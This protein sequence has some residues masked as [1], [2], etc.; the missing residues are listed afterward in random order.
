MSF[1]RYLGWCLIPWL[2]WCA[3]VWTNA[4]LIGGDL[5]IPRVATL[6]ILLVPFFQKVSTIAIFMKLGSLVQAIRLRRL[7][8]SFEVHRYGFV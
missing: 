5:H 4:G 6:C 2:V 8:L 1:S 7:E 3:L